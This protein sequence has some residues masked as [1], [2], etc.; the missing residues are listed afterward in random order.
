MVKEAL[1]EC[2]DKQRSILDYFKNWNSSA[3]IWSNNKTLT[4]PPLN[5]PFA[6]PTAHVKVIIVVI[7]ANCK[8]EK[9]SRILL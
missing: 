1:K 8:F 2:D 6:T 7:S 3:T 5:Q 4:Y 9:T